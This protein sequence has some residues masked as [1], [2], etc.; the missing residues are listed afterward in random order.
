M[1]D[2]IVAGSIFLCTFVVVCIIFDCIMRS[3]LERRMRQTWDFIH[4]MKDFVAPETKIPD[5][6]PF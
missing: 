6:V 2:Y 1:E 5:R 3:R 4:N